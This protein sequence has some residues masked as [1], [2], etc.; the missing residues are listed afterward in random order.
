MK[1]KRIIVLGHPRS[2]TG[3]LA[4]IKQLGHEKFNENGTSNWMLVPN[5]KREEGD[6]LIHVLRNPLDVIS[7]TLFTLS[8]DSINYLRTHTGVENKSMMGTV[9]SCWIKW[10]EMIEELKPD[11]TVKIEYVGE[12]KNK[13][14]HPNI[15]WEDLR[16]LPKGEYDQLWEAAKKYGY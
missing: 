14:N 6:Y 13:R 10:N 15:T 5:Y 4:H 1:P 7:S 2:G 11:E 8:L 12:V 9:S 3:T 16:Y